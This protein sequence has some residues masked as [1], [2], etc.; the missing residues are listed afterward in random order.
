VC[1]SVCPQVNSRSCQWRNYLKVQ[2]SLHQKTLS[3]DAEPDHSPN[4]G[5]FNGMCDR[6]IVRFC[7]QP[8]NE[9]ALREM[10]TLHGG[11]SKVEPKIFAPP[12]TPFL[13][14]QDS[15]NLISW[16][17]SLPSP[18]ETQFGEDWYT[19]LRVI[20]V[21]DPQTNTQTRKQTDRTDYNT[22]HP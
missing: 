9:K 3:F 4:P 7:I 19:Q 14:V 1:V 5:I 16:R 20:V 22:L 8:N 12:Q 6:G 17:W 18:T 11:C 2:T 13:E 10:Q 21:T 15:Q